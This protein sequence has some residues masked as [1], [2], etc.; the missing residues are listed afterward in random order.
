MNEI[1]KIREENGKQAVSARELYLFLEVRSDFTDW[2]KR[3]FEYGFED[4]KDFTLILGK[5]SG[6]RP[7]TDYALSLDCAKEISMLQ[8]T[9]KGK[10]ARQYFIEM[11]KKATAQLSTLDILEISIKKLREQEQ[12]MVA[13][14]TDVKQ[15]KAATQARP[16]VFTAAGFLTIKGIPATI[17]TCVKIGKAAT[18]VCKEKGWPIDTMPDPRFG[19]VNVYPTDA[20]NVAYTA[21]QF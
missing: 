16:E 5:S 4:N 3:M 21:V 9:E 19:K 11:E 12:R 14:E 20:L 1:I 2:C 10:Q 18:K 17:Q 8:R 13:V 7:S 6:G 15:L